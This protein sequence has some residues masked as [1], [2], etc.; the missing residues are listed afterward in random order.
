MHGAAAQF[1]HGDGGIGMRHAIH[2]YRVVRTAGMDVPG[3]V[4]AAPPHRHGRLADAEAPVERRVDGEVQSGRIRGA[5]CV[6]AVGAVRVEV[7]PGPLRGR[8][9]PR[10]RPAHTLGRR[11]RHTRQDTACRP[12]LELVAG[13]AGIRV[14]TVQL[15][16]TRTERAHLRG[17]VV[18]FVAAA[19]LVDVR[20][21]VNERLL[22]AAVVKANALHVAGE[23]QERLVLRLVPDVR[24]PPPAVVVAH[25]QAG[26]DEHV[27]VEVQTP[28]GI[29]HR[30][31]IRPGD[32]EG[33]AISLAR[34]LVMKRLA[35]DGADRE[36]ELAILAI[37]R[38]RARREPDAAQ[39]ERV[40]AEQRRVQVI[41]QHAGIERQGPAIGQ[42]DAPVAETLGR[43]IRRV[44]LDRGRPAARSDSGRKQEH[45]RQQRPHTQYSGAAS[46]TAGSFSCVQRCCSSPITMF[47]LPL[48]RSTLST[49]AVSLSTQMANSGSSL[50]VSSTLSALT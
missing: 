21:D 12:V 45:R 27:A 37:L 34:A 11:F 47:S 22:L 38:R 43:R 6:M 32:V 16:G 18:R 20:H 50:P 1:R 40:I 9:V 49:S 33:S 29:Q 31:A 24:Q 2:E 7:G 44:H 15:P 3:T 30:L 5:V 4:A 17:R 35:E 14:L 25:Q 46:I 10:R 42:H 41:G 19:A 26:L 8:R 13:F 36:L 39:L 23:F 48:P 28:A